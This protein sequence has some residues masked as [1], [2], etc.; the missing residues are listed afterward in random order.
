M[1][2]I[3]TNILYAIAL[4]LG[5]DLTSKYTNPIFCLTLVEVRDSPFGCPSSN[6]FSIVDEE[7]DPQIDK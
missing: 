1:L 3:I 7:E 4:R 6:I 5:K 2:M